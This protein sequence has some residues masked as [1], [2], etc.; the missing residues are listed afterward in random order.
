MLHFHDL[1]SLEYY[2]GF[3]LEDYL[4]QLTYFHHLLSSSLERCEPIKPDPPVKTIFIFLPWCIQN[5]VSF[6]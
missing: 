2:L 6:S 3:Q 5:R 1:I 4:Q